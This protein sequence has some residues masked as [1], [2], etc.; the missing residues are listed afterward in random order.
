MAMGIV[1][2]KDYQSETNKLNPSKPKEKNITPPKEKERGPNV[3]DSLRKLIGD[4]AESNGRSEA[5]A[6]A[7]QFGIS[8]SSASAYGVGATSTRTYDDRPNAGIIRGA[9]ERISKKARAKLMLALNHITEDKIENV[10][11]KD[12]AGIAKDMSA[13]VRNMDDEPTTKEND[14]PTKPA[15]L[16]YAP[17]VNQENHYQTVIA[18]E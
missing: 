7:A 6:L 14:G 18:K 10:S 16:V 9:K 8:P 17:T 2:D 5:V 1:S 15:F 12:L 3:P 11:A 4:T 13:I